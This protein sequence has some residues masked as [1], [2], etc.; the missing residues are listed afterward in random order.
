MLKI[1]NIGCGP[2]GILLRAYLYISVHTDK[3]NFCEMDSGMHRKNI[4]PRILKR[5]NL[6]KP[7]L[8]YLM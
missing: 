1:K 5:Q 8:S 6:T 3:T 7:T 2:Q 4:C